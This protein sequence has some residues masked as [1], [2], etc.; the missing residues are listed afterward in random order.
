VQCM[1]RRK[2]RETRPG[3]STRKPGDQPEAV[4]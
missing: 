2:S 1:G 3:N 4:V